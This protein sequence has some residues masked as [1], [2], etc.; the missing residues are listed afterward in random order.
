MTRAYRVGI[1]GVCHVH[2]HNV[3]NVFKS[4]PQVELVACADTKPAIEECSRVAYTRA[5]NLDYLR[6]TMG[7]PKLYDDHEQMLASEKLD[8]V[9]CNSENSEHPAVVRACAAA[10][11]NVCVEKPMAASLA[12]ARDGPSGA[13]REDRGRGSLVHALLPVHAAGRAVDS[14]RGHRARAGIPDARGPCGAAG[15][16]SPASRAEH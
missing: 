3:A 2:V 7:V 4:H 5:W 14:R 12:D 15:S 13:I 9:I 16:G 1:I 8:I 11:V 6:N 10:G